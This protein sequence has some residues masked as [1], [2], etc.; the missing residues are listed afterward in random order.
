MKD[1]VGIGAGTDLAFWLEG[2][3]SS[4]PRE[5]ESEDESQTTRCL[6]KAFSNLARVSLVDDGGMVRGVSFRRGLK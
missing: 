6:L 4:S 3:C 2:I 5:L 1:W